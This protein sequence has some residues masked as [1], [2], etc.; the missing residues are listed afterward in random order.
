MHQPH[1][2]Q[3][4]S[5][6]GGSNSDS[7]GSANSLAA[8]QAVPSHLNSLGDEATAEFASFLR[9]TQSWSHPQRTDRSGRS[10]SRTTLSRRGSE[11]NQG[12]RRRSTRAG[13]REGRFSAMVQSAHHAR[14]LQEAAKVKEEQRRREAEHAAAAAAKEAEAERQRRAVAA[15]Q[16][17]MG[18]SSMG[19]MYGAGMMNPPVNPYVNSFGSMYNMPA[20]APVPAQPQWGAG[21][22]YAVAQSTPM[23]P[24]YAAHTPMSARGNARARATSLEHDHAAFDAGAFP[25]PPPGVPSLN[26]M[27]GSSRNGSGHLMGPP[28]PSPGFVPRTL[29]YR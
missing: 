29:S 9:E 10:T 7:N 24:G 21:A 3:S 23:S 28:G 14:A 6:N 26:L 22:P 16:A 27:G 4:V 15:A 2:P 20:M 8:H 5:L 1:T 17:S 12:D 18:L 25:P 13:T 19:S 11:R